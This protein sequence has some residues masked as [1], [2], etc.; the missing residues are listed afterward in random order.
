MIICSC[1]VLTDRDVRSAIIDAGT[2]VRTACEVEQNR[3]MGR[4]QDREPGK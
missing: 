3:A 2:A 1:N 4:D